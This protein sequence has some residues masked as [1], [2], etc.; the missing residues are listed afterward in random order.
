MTPVDR[1]RLAPLHLLL[2]G[3]AVAVA[4]YIGALIGFTLTFPSA[5][6]TSVLWPPN[7]IVTVALLLLPLRYWWLCFAAALPVHLLLELDAG[8]SPLVVALLFLTNC[9]EAVI[10]AGGM[11]LLSD[12][13]TEFNTLRRVVVFVGVAGLAAP[14]LSSFADAAVFHLLEGQPYWDIWRVRTSSNTLTELSVV[15]VAVLGVRAL[16]RGLHLPSARRLGEAALLAAALALVGA[17]VF[18]GV[19]DLRGVPPT[20]SVLLLPL[21]L[22]AAARFGVAGVSVALLGTAFAAA[23]E[24]QHGNRPFAV[25]PPVDSLIAVQMYLTVLGIP[26]MCLAGLLAERRR[27]A[28]YLRERLRFEGLLST[29]AADFVSQPQGASFERGLGYVGEFF[30][31]DY[32]GLLQDGGATGELHVEWQWH[33]PSGA[34]LV[35]A[36]CVGAFPWTFGRVLAGETVRID[37]A[38]SFPPEAEADRAAFQR[39]GL[40]SAMVL[41]LLAGSRVQ[42]AMSLVMMRPGATPHW[43]GQQLALV[44]EVLANACARRQAELEVERTRQKLAT[45]ARHSSMGELTASLAH[46]LNQPLT[47]IRNNAEAARRFIDAGR[48]TLPQLREIL[49]D[50]IDD[51]RRAADVIRRVREILAR[52]EWAPRRLDANALVQD[53][54]VLIASDAVLRNVS[55]SY[56]CSPEPIFV[57]GNRV[58]L[59]QVLLNV[60]TNAMD[61]V[62]ERPVPQRVVTIQTRR[63]GD[64]RVLFVVRDRGVGFTEGFDKKMFE[65]FVTTK[66]TG[67]GMGL[68]VARSLLDNHGGTIRAANHAEGGAVVTIAIP[69]TE[70]PA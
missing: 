6:P 63:D 44:A 24:T 7:S 8:M 68:A 11:R 54:G 40:Q 52:S 1:V 26:L 58:D 45:M 13:P 39:F 27:G 66:P 48:A 55:V 41:P 14:I 31:A 28:T 51:D 61:A 23:Y 9:S 33:Q 3:A 20:P 42:G 62:A 50:I 16:L 47:G 64:G 70:V 17:L 15:P 12:S 43:D 37:G 65:P 56:D 29:I 38:T 60:V 69:A 32:V 5:G 30:D 2:A 57:T 10:A 18:G 19:L 46:Q 25:L 35:G 36:N 34:A 21:F 67:M 22:W 59:E 53:V 49:I 4:Y